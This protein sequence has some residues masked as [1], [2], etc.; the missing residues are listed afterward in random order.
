MT[1]AADSIECGRAYSM[2]SSSPSISRNAASI[3][4]SRMLRH[5]V[6]STA[7]VTRSSW[8]KPPPSRDSRPFHLSIRGANH[9]SAAFS[10]PSSRRS[11]RNPP[12]TRSANHVP[13]VRVSTMSFMSI[14]PFR[15]VSISD[16]TR[17]PCA[18]AER[19]GTRRRKR[20]RSAWHAGGGRKPL[21]RFHAAHP[22]RACERPDNTVMRAAHGLRLR[23]HAD[24][25]EYV[26]RA[27]PG[28]ILF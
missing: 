7:S 18:Q 5:S 6:A 12:H 11:L 13:V 17:L 22:P 15:V 27:L 24:E 2:C 16:T 3:S 19:H 4:A 8:E 21:V 9:L 10:G 23:S 14:G 20:R 28:S 26:E 1:T 25:G